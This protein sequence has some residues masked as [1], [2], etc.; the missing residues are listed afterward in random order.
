MRTFDE[1]DRATGFAGGEKFVS[2][3]Q[4]RD[5]FTVSNMILMFGECQ[6]T[7]TELDDMAETVIANRFWLI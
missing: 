5:Y 7:Q 6:N 2:E 1:I 4:V 3:E